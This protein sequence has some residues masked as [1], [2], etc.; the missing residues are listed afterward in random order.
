MTMKDTITIELPKFY[1]NLD[2]PSY[3][4]ELEENQE[5][6]EELQ[7]EIKELRSILLLRDK[8]NGV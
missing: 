8:Y 4:K 5:K 7:E 2:F 6:V 1:G 3:L